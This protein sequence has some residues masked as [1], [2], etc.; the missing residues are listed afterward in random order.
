LNR[1]S[2]WLPHMAMDRKLGLK[3]KPI[4]ARQNA[5]P[6][7]FRRI[8]FS[9]A[10]KFKGLTP[11]LREGLN[12]IGMNPSACLASESKSGPRSALFFFFCGKKPRG[13]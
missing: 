2:Q 8:G 4:H 3:F 1:N 12:S 7:L 5:V 11:A 10:T 13:G 9:L 6:M